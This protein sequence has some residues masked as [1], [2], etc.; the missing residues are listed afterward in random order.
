MGLLVGLKEWSAV[1]ESLGDG[2][3]TILLR[4]YPSKPSEF[5]LFPT[6]NYVRTRP[7]FPDE[8]SEKFQ[9][10]YVE[11]ARRTGETTRDRARE[12]FADIKYWA[13]IDSVL[14]VPINRIQQIADHTIWSRKHVQDYANI[15]R[16]G[17]FIW[18]VRLNK[19]PETVPI[20]RYPGGGV[21]HYYRHTEEI[22]TTGSYPVLSDL[23]YT[24]QKEVLLA[25]LKS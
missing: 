17:L 21:P 7:A 24:R 15:S 4:G 9:P 5:F 19:F 23:D 13:R 8:F 18:I 6:F 1:V 16:N 25:Y 10:K 22:P 2:T 12:F 14:P 11:M 3:Q 20:Q